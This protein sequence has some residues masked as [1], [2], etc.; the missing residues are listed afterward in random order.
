MTRRR[1]FCTSS[2]SSPTA[3]CYNRGRNEPPSPRS[4][5]ARTIV[6]LKRINLTKEMQPDPSFLSV[7]ELPI[8]P[9]HSSRTS[10]APSPSSDESDLR[11][12]SPVR[13][14]RKGLST[15]RIKG[16]LPSLPG[17]RDQEDALWG[18]DSERRSDERLLPGEL[19]IS[20]PTDNAS[21]LTVRVD[22]ACSTYDPA[23]T[24]PPR[25]S[26]SVKVRSL[27]DLRWNGYRS[28]HRASRSSS[29]KA[30][31]RSRWP[32]CVS[33]QRLRSSSPPAASRSP[34][35]QLLLARPLSL[36]R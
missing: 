15:R 23:S 25:R 32:R 22:S 28:P 6:P 24:S 17:R 14:I 33:L 29:S 4:P 36:R 9:P 27:P 2:P 20:M 31:R 30:Q 16:S 13:S 10:L 21:E 5:T 8:P 3:L 34:Q 7:K 18:T 12:G 26:P 19:R 1:R 35:Q 11:S